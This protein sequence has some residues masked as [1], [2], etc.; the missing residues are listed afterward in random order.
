MKR[1]LLSLGILLCAFTS[2]AYADYPEG[3]VKWIED[4]GLY[5]TTLPNSIAYKLPGNVKYYPFRIKGK[6]YESIIGRKT[7]PYERY[8]QKKIRGGKKFKVLGYANRIAQVDYDTY[9]IE[10]GGLIYLLPSTYATDNTIIKTVNKELKEPYESKKKEFDKVQKE[11]NTMWNTLYEESKLQCEYFK[12]Q[13]NILPAKIDSAGMAMELLYRSMKQEAFDKW[14]NSL[15]NSTKHIYNNVIEITTARLG[16]QNS[17]GG[18]DCHFNY[19]NKSKKTIKYLDWTGSFYNAVHDRV[20]CDIRGYNNYTGQDTGPVTTG[21]HGGGTW[22]CVIYD[23]AADYVKIE[24]VSIIYMDG[25]RISIGASDIK[26]LLTS[27]NY[28]AIFDKYGSEWTAVNNAKKPFEELLNNANVELLKWEGR[29]ET[30]SRRNFK[31][32]VRYDNEYIKIYETLDK[33]QETYYSCKFFIEDFEE[34]NLMKL[35]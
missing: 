13:Q 3:D 28:D 22:D 23:W 15:P 33:L 30:L 12:N 24:Y 16:S 14:Y 29:K 5:I 27:P 18:C 31:F 32:P 1:Y 10:I 35:Q 25:T 8:K 4:T 34:K 9:A 6:S 2:L 7:I 21:Q 20:Y 26:Y 11:Y 19:L 17:A